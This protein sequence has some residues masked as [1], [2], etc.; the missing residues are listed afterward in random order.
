MKKILFIILLMPLEL[1]AQ[2]DTGSISGSLIST[3]KYHFM[4]NIISSDTVFAIKSY[5]NTPMTLKVFDNASTSTDRK[6]LM[7]TDTAGN[8]HVYGDTLS[9]LKA[10]IRSYHIKVKQ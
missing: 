9:V 8:I 7:E 6:L 5:S 4:P 1:M 10:I 2:K 3:G